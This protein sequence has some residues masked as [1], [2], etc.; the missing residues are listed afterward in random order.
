VL[1]TWVRGVPPRVSRAPRARARS[2]AH[3]AQPPSSSRAARGPPC[4]SALP[5]CAPLPACPTP[6]PCKARSRPLAADLQPPCRRRLRRAAAQ[7]S[8]L[9]ARRYSGPGRHSHRPASSRSR[10]RR[11]SSTIRRR[12]PSRSRH[13]LGAPARDVCFPSRPNQHGLLS[14]EPRRRSVGRISSRARC[15]R[16]TLGSS[17][18]GAPR[19]RTRVLRRVPPAHTAT[20][21][22]SADTEDEWSLDTRE[23]LHPLVPTELRTRERTRSSLRLSPRRSS[24]RTRRHVPSAPRRAS[25]LRQAPPAPA[26]SLWRRD[27]AASEGANSP[28]TARAT[29]ASIDLPSASGSIRGRRSWLIALRAASDP[30]IASGRAHGRGLHSLRILPPRTAQPIELQVPPRRSGSAESPTFVTAS[31]GS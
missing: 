21:S 11:G 25:F 4:V 28:S 20:F 8:W 29:T 16:P 15:P 9:D 5:L 31:L 10:P 3:R 6:R 12:Q 22:S 19:S 13:T 18:V 17:R 2:A 26:S 27:L 14:R 30:Q 7:P 23:R 24:G 1:P